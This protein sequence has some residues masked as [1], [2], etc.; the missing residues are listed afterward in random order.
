MGSK[1][2]TSNV[3]TNDT[4][5]RRSDTMLTDLRVLAIVNHPD[6]RDIYTFLL[7]EEGAAVQ[8]AENFSQAFNLLD[9]L[10]PQLIIIDI[11]SSPLFPIELLTPIVHM[12]YWAKRQNSKLSIITLID[13]SQSYPN[14]VD[15][16]ARM[17]TLLYRPLDI[18]QL[19]DTVYQQMPDHRTE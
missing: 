14:T 2:I 11:L 10:E 15:Q 3:V 5:A 1:K 8:T 4:S 12:K 17:T 13:T 18:D 19:L 7:T 16:L 9:E 6:L